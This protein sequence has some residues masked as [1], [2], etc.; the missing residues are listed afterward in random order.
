MSYSEILKSFE[1]LHPSDIAYSLKKIKKTDK[2]LFY[3]LIANIADD[4]LGE[5]LLELPENIR[6]AA[7]KALS[8]EK[9]TDAVEEL[10]TDD[11]TDIIKDIEEFDP[12]KA[13]DILDGLDEED[14][15]EINWLKK[16]EDD[17]AGASMQTELFSANINEIV[18]QAVQRLKKQKEEGELENIHQV[19]IV[20]DNIALLAS[21]SLE[22]LIIYDFNLTFKEILKNNEKYYKTLSVEADDEIMDVVK[23]FEDYDLSVVAV[24]GYKN[25]LI[26]RITSDD[27][28]DVAGQT[29]TEQMYQLAG[30]NDEFEH[31]DDLITTSKKRGFWLLIN[32]F[33]AILAS[34]VI[35]IFDDVLKEF[36]ALAILMPIVASM[37]G[38]AGTQTLAV[39]V[40]QLALGEI[41]ETNKK[42]AVKKEIFIAIF[43]GII[44]A[45]ALGI[46]T[47]LW[48]TNVMLGVVIFSSMIITI[49]SAGFFGSLIPLILKR[50][51]IDPAIGSSVV[52]T[53]VTDVVGFFSFLGLAKLILM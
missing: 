14:Q 50:V 24:I 37:G 34:V 48:F 38:N 44:F 5:V 11:A 47:S 26:G 23:L 42:D 49:F 41:D 30:V 53:T 2:E 33:T 4:I 17:E 29:A 36:I 18:I 52:L 16:Y 25:R 15:E 31:E 51:D 6:D 27:I 39:M 1:E 9:L 45:I 3:K 12:K 35:G 8:I 10:E 7:Y 20:D 28:L 22:D 21:I 43:N 46:L 19:F 13:D 40:R 32:L